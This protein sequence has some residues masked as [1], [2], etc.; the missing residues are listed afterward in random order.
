MITDP[1][2][3]PRRNDLPWLR[4]R[5]LPRSATVHAADAATPGAAP[6]REFLTGHTTGEHH[7]APTPPPAKA[8]PPPA[9]ATP[10]Q[11]PRV[12]EPAAPP[13]AKAAPTQPPR[14]R[15]PAASAPSSTSLDLDESAPQ[16]APQPAAPAP[17]STSLDLDAPAPASSSST[18]LDLDE[19]AAAARVPAPPAPSRTRSRTDVRVHAGDRMLLTPSE[20]SVTLTP[21]QSGI[22]ALT[23]EAAASDAVGDL[24]LGAAYELASGQQNVMQ[25]TQGSRLAPP[26]SKRP[27]LLGSRDRFEKVSVDLRQCRHLRR[28]ALYAFSEKRKPL[29]WGGTLLVTTFG[30]ARIELP[31]DSL[32]GGDIAV[33]LSIYQVRGEFVLRAEMQAL[34][35]DVREASRAYGYDRISWL[36]GRTP[37]E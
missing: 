3:A 11:P 14:V 13:P 23:L 35:G 24:R 10:T 4:R 20:P 25:M 15:E 30:G 21:L 22:G 17:S 26:H 36:D 19:P 28:L 6:L 1:R 29:T 31:L 16:S 33:L 37:V 18:S 9:K 2:F 34:F 12:C 32:Q 27:I 7:H 8:A 5:R